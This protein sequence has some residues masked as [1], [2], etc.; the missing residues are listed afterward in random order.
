MAPF[1][2]YLLTQSVGIVLL[3]SLLSQK[4]NSAININSVPQTIHA[5]W[6]TFYDK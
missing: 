6:A 1:G 4:K 2:E 5:R 3:N